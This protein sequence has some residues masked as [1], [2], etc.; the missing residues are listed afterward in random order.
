MRLSM[1]MN[2]AGGFK[3][4]VQQVA[5]LERAGL[6]IVWV[7]EAYSFDAVSILGYLAARTSKIGLAA[8]A[9]SMNC[10]VASPK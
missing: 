10:A 1:Q 3:E 7:P 8:G 9:V 6:D 4:T 2:Y 5:D